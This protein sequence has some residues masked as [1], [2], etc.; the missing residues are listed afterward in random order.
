MHLRPA[1]LADAPLLR[2]WDEAPHV[3]AASG[4]DDGWDWETGLTTPLPGYEMLIAEEDGRPVGFMQILDPHRDPTRYWGV[5]PP[6]FRA[7]DIWIGPAECLGR[8]F[9]TTMMRAAIARCF[10][11]PEVTAIVIDPLATNTRA[12][13]FYRRMGF[14]DIGPRR[15]GKDECLVMRLDWPAKGIA[16]P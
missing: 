12:I 3:S 16:Q 11:E 8:G 13:R 15:F 5:M 14:R 7:I 10:A 2:R 6:G 1:T 9:G 4:D